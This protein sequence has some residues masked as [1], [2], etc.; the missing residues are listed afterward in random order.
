MASKCSCHPSNVLVID[1]PSKGLH[2]DV[3]HGLFTSN[4]SYPPETNHDHN[5]QND[6]NWYETLLQNV[7]WHRV[8]YKSNRFQ[9]S[10]E[11]PCYTTFYGGR[12][13]YH[14]Y[15]PIPSWFQPLIDQVTSHLQTNSKSKVR[16]NA[17]LLRLYFDGND[18]IAWH[19]DGRTFLG[20]DPTIAS[21]S[22]GSPATF[23]L[24]RMNDLW[25]CADG[26]TSTSG[27]VDVSTP[28]KSFRLRDGDLLVM[29]GETQRYWHH[30]VP[31][32]KGRGVR[33]NV[34]FRYILPGMDAERGQMT[35]YKYMVYGDCPVGDGLPKSWTFEE[36]MA[37]K[38]GMRNFVQVSG[39]LD[40]AMK[41]HILDHG[42]ETSVL[43]QRSNE[44]IITVHEDECSGVAT[45][46]SFKESL[47]QKGRSTQ[48]VDSND[49]AKR[50]SIFMAKLTK[51]CNQKSKSDI[52]QFLSS[53]ETIDRSVFFSLPSYIQNELVSQ[54]KAY[55]QSACII[56][57]GKEKNVAMV[58]PTGTSNQKRTKDGINTSKGTKPRKSA[59]GTLDSFFAKM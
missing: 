54:W 14:P 13:E 21:L 41:K 50:D 25:P 27:C 37:K 33:L 44:T 9:K 35:Y 56:E 17:V 15:H 22:L 55:R 3:H 36:I 43:D 30:R 53:D 10:C 45:N 5:F 8:K 39:G 59:K 40:G 31:R 47:Q 26:S 58:S 2:V 49:K 12:P 34:N 1:N 23:Q 38:G 32:E 29:R 20:K 57:T 48:Q 42:Q 51:I 24:R 52:Q 6:I 4:K 19:T 11:T 46:E 18:E 7:S 28:M 16:F